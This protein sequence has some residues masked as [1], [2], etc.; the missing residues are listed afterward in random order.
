MNLAHKGA[1]A[2][3][4]ALLLAAS[5]LL[6]AA[7]RTGNTHRA[8]H[9]LS[10]STHRRRHS[11]SL[12]TKSA[13]TSR[14]PNAYQRLAKMQMDP[15]RVESI[16]RALSDAGVYHGSPTGQW[17]S[18]TRDAMARYQAQSGFG[19]TGLPDAKSLMKLGLG[20]H[21]LPA[22]LDKKRASNIQP[23]TPGSTSGAQPDSAAG[24]GTSSAPDAPAVPAGQD[25][26]QR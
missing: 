18:E 4:L 24:G 26:P 20:P 25:P 15:G 11:S 7:S 3:L 1:P 14:R 21:P 16:Q 9:A 10:S 23:N 2:S 13:R 6:G 17:D 22:E 19:V 8:H 12:T 5:P